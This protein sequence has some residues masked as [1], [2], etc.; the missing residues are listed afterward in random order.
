MDRMKLNFQWLLV[1][2]VLFFVSNIAI[3]Y[4]LD[5]SYRNM[6]FYE[7]EEEMSPEVTITEAKK[8]R[9]N[10]YIK[11][12]L[13]NKTNKRIHDEYIRF[14]FYNEQDKKTGTEY[15]KIEDLRAGDTIDFEQ[16]FKFTKVN[17]F[18]VSV[19]EEPTYEEVNID[20]PIKY[21]SII[22]LM[23]SV[24]VWSA[25]PALFFGII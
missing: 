9:M 11:G 2:V 15:Y 17:S 3:D 8:A 4:I 20:F 12:Q 19:S 24:I 14:D 7:L 18:K 25:T 1:F 5:T 10:G 22:W 13:T 16:H 21:P 6:K 23:A